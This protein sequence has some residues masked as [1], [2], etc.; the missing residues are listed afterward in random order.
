MEQLKDL[1]TLNGQLESIEEKI[2]LFDL[3]ENEKNQLFA[4]QGNLLYDHKRNMEEITRKRHEFL[5]NVMSDSE[6]VKINVKAQRDIANFINKFRQIIQKTTG[7]DEGIRNIEENIS[8]NNWSIDHLK[9]ILFKTKIGEDNST[10][11]GRFRRMITSLNDEQLDEIRLLFP[12][13]EIEVRYKPNEN[14]QF[15]SLSTASAGQ[16][17]SAI[18][19]FLLS[20][21]NCPL[22]LD[23]PEDDLDNQLIHNLIVDRLL[24]CKETRQIIVITHNANIPVNGDAE[25]VTSLDSDTRDISIFKSGFVDYPDIK[26]KICDIMEGGEK[27]F[28]LRA[29]RYGF[30]K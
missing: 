24:S 18:L 25:W 14:G 15:K 20:Y 21:G 13:D 1:S 4:D 16:K 12:E 22:I 23:Q 27:A 9:E 29:L 6:N 7:Y 5:Q 26:K 11:D 30:N 10:F 17:T 2:T 3:L 8:S 28:T 19:T